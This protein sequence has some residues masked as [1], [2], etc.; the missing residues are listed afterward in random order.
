MR[1]GFIGNMTAACHYSLCKHL[2][3]ANKRQSDMGL[4]SEFSRS[5]DWA[6][7][8]PMKVCL[9]MCWCWI[10][11]FWEFGVCFDCK[12]G[13][14]AK[15]VKA[16]RTYR[17]GNKVFILV[18]GKRWIFV[19]RVSDAF[20]FVCPYVFLEDKAGQ[21]GGGLLNCQIIEETVEHHLSQQE[22]VG[23]GDIYTET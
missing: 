16:A 14:E 8:K 6:N 2:K 3:L 20:V 19:H 5:Q 7:E 4:R 12:A 21:Q 11:L 13:E 17:N 9:N 1:T 10:N 18:F 15:N 22:L 23:T